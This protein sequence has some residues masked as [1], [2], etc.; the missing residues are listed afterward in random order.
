MC[1]N[2]VCSNIAPALA[3]SAHLIQLSVIFV[4]R[5]VPNAVAERADGE[6]SEQNGC[7]DRGMGEEKREGCPQ[8]LSPLEKLK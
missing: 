1:S 7:T 8:H 4:A 5:V 3:S 2:N 6:V